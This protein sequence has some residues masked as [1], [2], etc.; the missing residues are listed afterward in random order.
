MKRISTGISPAYVQNWSVEKAIREIIQ[1]YLDIRE[2]FGVGGRITWERGIAYV[3][4]LGDG[5]EMRHLAMGISEKGEDAIG[6]YG[7]GLKLAMLVMA[8]EDREIE[9]R[10]RGKIIRPKIVYDPSF[11]T[12]VMALEIEE[13]ESIVT[14]TTV[15]FL[16]SEEEL[17][18]G[19]GY[20]SRFLTARG[21]IEW[22]ETNRISLPGGFLY[23]NGA[24]VGSI[25]GGSLYSYHVESPSD[26]DIGNR[27]REV[28][29]MEKAVSA[30][31]PI[32]WNTR[33]KEV[34]RRIVKALS[35]PECANMAEVTSL[36]SW[37]EYVFQSTLR[38]WGKAFFE[39]YGPDAV[40]AWG[41]SDDVRLAK[42]MG[43]DVVDLSS[44]RWCAALNAGGVPYDRD[45]SRDFRAQFDIVP[46]TD[47]TK[48]EQ[49]NLETAIALIAEYY[50]QPAEVQ[51]SEDLNRDLGYSSSR[52]TIQGIYRRDEER[53]ILR[54]SIL[55]DFPKTVEILLHE[56]VHQVSGA[57][58]L[59]EEFQKAQDSL[60]ARL[61]LTLA[62]NL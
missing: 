38:K 45:V 59:S 40:I 9:V 28:I 14:G 5:L 43:K 11:E 3:R 50:V 51:I 56:T 47:L 60:S 49:S 39:V 17:E 52:M 22:V 58:D 4:D 62:K 15:R 13:D 42:Y 1:N 54:R 41:D 37:D 16:C 27:D 57:K 44:W 18:S 46:K 36:S 23:L 48:E 61:L 6:Q 12:E 26:R 55:E 7:E 53:I 31:A 2:E 32:M 34:R 33:S 24:K 8:R 29:D 20:F 19:K 21:D 10:A 30:I 25:P 35:D